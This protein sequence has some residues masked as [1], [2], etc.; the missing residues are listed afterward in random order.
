MLLAGIQ[1]FVVSTSLPDPVCES[2][3]VLT[4]KPKEKAGPMKEP[5]F[6]DP[7]KDLYKVML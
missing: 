6:L 7:M 4:D 5:A 1:L 3:V 2:S